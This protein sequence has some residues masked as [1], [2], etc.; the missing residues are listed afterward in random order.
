[1][2]EI[3]GKVT[4]SPSNSSSSSMRISSGISYAI[5]AKANEVFAGLGVL[6]GSCIVS[7]LE[8]ASFSFVDGAIVYIDDALSLLVGCGDSLF[9][10]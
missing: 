6:L 5:V 1:M 3:G 2:G 8:L 7:G 10:V 9:G 4:S